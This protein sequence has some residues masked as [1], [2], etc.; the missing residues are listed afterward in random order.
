MFNF[1]SGSDVDEIKP[2]D[3]NEKLS[4]KEEV[5]ILDVRKSSKFKQ[6]SID[7]VNGEIFNYSSREVM[8]GLPDEIEKNLSD[9]EVVVVCYKGNI[10]KKVAAKLNEQLGNDVK[11]LQ[12]GMAGWRKV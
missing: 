11:S 1:F 5:L 12:K 8:K 3:L 4:S 6:D 9:Q 2:K 10:S 7:P